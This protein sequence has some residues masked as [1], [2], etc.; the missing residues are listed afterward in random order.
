MVRGVASSDTASVEALRRETIDRRTWEHT[1]Q[2]DS[3][4]KW[5]MQAGVDRIG[6]GIIQMFESMDRCWLQLITTTFVWHSLWQRQSA[7]CWLSICCSYFP[8]VE[9][10]SWIRRKTVTMFT[11]VEVKSLT[12][13]HMHSSHS[14]CFFLS[15]AQNLSFWQMCKCTYREYG[16]FSVWESIKLFLSSC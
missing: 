3:H 4:Q 15:P 13:R 9:C 14:R 7:V 12:D 10:E 1:E 6:S 2:I 11:A 8:A 16:L 5:I